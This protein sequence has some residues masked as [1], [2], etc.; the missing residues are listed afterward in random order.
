MAQLDVM[1]NM[2]CRALDTLFFSSGSLRL[3]PL[4]T[5]SEPIPV[6]FWMVLTTHWKHNW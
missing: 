3:G 6:Q 5:P 2:A 4:F 1:K